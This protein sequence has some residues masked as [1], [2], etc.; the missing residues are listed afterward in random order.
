MTTIEKPIALAGFPV[1]TTVSVQWG[2]QDVFGH[3]NN[4]SYFRW[5]ESNRMEYAVRCGMAAAPGGSQLTPIL[6]KITCNYRQQLRHPD[7]LYIGGRMIRIGTSSMTVEHVVYS[8]QQQ[9]L[10]ADGESIMVLFDYQTQRSRT[11]P[12]ELRS[13]IEAL[14]GRPFE[15]Q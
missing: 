11:V 3:A 14:E 4:V 15:T 13:S 12:A 2:D 7:D 1:V 5:F 10:V 9:A 8:Q 6:V